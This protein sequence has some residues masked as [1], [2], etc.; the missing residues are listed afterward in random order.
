MGP[1][2]VGREVEEERGVERSSK[3]ILNLKC[4]R[5]LPKRVWLFGDIDAI[6]WDSEK[7]MKMLSKTPIWLLFFLPLFGCCVARWT[8]NLIMAQCQKKKNSRY[9]S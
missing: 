7:V 5:F 8:A 3:K 6:S 4:E 9:L 1:E 2:G